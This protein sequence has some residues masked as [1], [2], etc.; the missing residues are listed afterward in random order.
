MTECICFVNISCYGH[1]V[2]VGGCSTNKTCSDPENAES[3]L[4]CK[5]SDVPWILPN[6]Y[7]IIATTGISLAIFLSAL[8]RYYQLKTRREVSQF[9][10]MIALI[11]GTIGCI[12]CVIMSVLPSN[13]LS[14]SV[15]R[16]HLLFAYAGFGLAFLYEVLHLIVAWRVIVRAWLKVFLTLCCIIPP[17]ALVIWTRGHKEHDKTSSL[18]EWICAASSYSYLL[19][20]SVWAWDK[21][22]ERAAGESKQTT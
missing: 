20:Y 16:S 3:Q 19:A 21:H 14:T 9:W 4:Y 10:N 7:F 1:G 12:S 18:G 22:N 13:H 5:P 2:T 8:G 6:M 11:V 15:W 17:F